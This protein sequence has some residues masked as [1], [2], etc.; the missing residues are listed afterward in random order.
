M[1]TERKSSEYLTEDELVRIKTKH[2]V[3]RW[4]IHLAVFTVVQGALIPYG[5]SIFN[6]LVHLL[7]GPDRRHDVAY[8]LTEGWT[9]VL[10]LDA[11]VVASWPLWPK[12]RDF[13]MERF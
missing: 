8:L 2:E 11:A 9:F 4:L 10:L 3:R 6:P 1:P 5:Y 12:V 13:V 7:G